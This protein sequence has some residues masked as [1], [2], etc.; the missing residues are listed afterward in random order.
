VH[1]TLPKVGTMRLATVSPADARNTTS[2]GRCGE[3]RVTGDEI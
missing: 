1:T 3:P 2:G